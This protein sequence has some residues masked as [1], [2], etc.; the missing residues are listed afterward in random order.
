MTRPRTRLVLRGAIRQSGRAGGQRARRGVV[1]EAHR[2]PLGHSEGYG[3]ALAGHGFERPILIAGRL[4]HGDGIVA[5]RHIGRQELINAVAVGVGE[6]G[7]KAVGRVGRRAADGLLE[8]TE[9]ADQH[10]VDAVGHPARIV[11]IPERHRPRLGYFQRDV[12]AVVDRAQPVV[13]VPRTIERR[14]VLVRPRLQNERA[15]PQ[16][17]VGVVGQH[18]F[19][20]LG[21]PV[22]GAAQWHLE[23]PGDGHHLGRFDV[24]RIVALG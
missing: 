5:G 14:L 18:R 8:V 12:G 1:G 9:D 10:V 11:V 21:V 4:G 16:V 22:A 17:A 13:V 3:I 23:R 19:F 20:A 2:L 6:Q 24:L 15:R 7:A